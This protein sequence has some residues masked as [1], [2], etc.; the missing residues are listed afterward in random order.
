MTFLRV[1][2]VVFVFA[3]MSAENFSYAQG[4]EALARSPVIVSEAQP[5]IVIEEYSH[6]HV[7]EVDDV[8]Q[9]KVY[10]EDDLSGIYKIGS[11]GMISF[12]LIGEIKVKGQ[13]TRDAAQLIK[14]KLLDGYL[15]NPRV[16]VEAVSYQPFY[17]LG[18]V[19]NPGSYRFT[20]SA[21]VLKAVEI[22]GGF[23]YRANKKEVQVLKT[24][25]VGSSDLH[26]KVPV[27][28]TIGPGDI[29]LVKERFF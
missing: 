25:E 2:I 16:S 4:L 17:I 21:T 3:V 10:G 19:R 13:S 28:S 8:I 9:V 11:A 22:A 23:T 24:K 15:V 5:E 20:N 27:D 1:F 26:E 29:I 12:P 18:E 7:L 14:M 6:S